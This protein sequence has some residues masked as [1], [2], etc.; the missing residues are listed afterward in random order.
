MMFERYQKVVRCSAGH[1]Y[2][3]IWMWGGS[4]KA[5]R[6]GSRRYQRCPVGRHWSMARV[7]DASSLTPAE[8]EQAAAIHD[9]PIP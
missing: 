3:S 9:L 7:V 2:T 4:I 6:L 5:L 8:R 1:L